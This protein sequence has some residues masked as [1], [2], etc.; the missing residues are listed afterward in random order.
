MGLPLRSFLTVRAVEYVFLENIFLSDGLPISNIY[1]FFRTICRENHQRNIAV[2]RFGNSGVIVQQRGARCA[3][4]SNGFFELLGNSHGKKRSA[5]FIDNAK[6]LKFRVRCKPN[7]KRCI[8]RTWR[9][10]D[11]M[12]SF[13]Q[14]KLY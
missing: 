8:P 7:R 5:P 13:S 14:T 9:D 6:T 3:D 1:K 4:Y 11:V 10:Y 12:D 2:E